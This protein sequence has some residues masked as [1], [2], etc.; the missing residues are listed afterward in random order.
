MESRRRHLSALLSCLIVLTTG[1]WAVRE[2]TAEPDLSVLYIDMAMTGRLTDK[3]AFEYRSE[4]PRP[5]EAR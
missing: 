3:T 1:I 4:H 2:S 5:R